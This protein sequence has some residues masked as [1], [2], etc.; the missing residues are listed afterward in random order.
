LK[1]QNEEETKNNY[2][3][4]TLR[5]PRV[6]SFLPG[7]ASFRDAAWCALNYACWFPPT[8]DNQQGVFKIRLKEEE[9]EEEEV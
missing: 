5:V 1:E 7:P 8:I 4:N 3:K 6:N 2:F 9:E